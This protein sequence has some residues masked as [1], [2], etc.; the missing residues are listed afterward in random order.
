MVTEPPTN[1]VEPVWHLA[2]TAGF[3]RAIQRLDKPAATR[4]LRY[5]THLTDLADPRLRGKALT[6]HL[7]GMW[8]YRIGDYRVITKINDQQLT[9]IALT[10]GHRSNI[11]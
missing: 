6:G 11:Y 7:T 8:R 10:V 5:L 4:I 2:T 1:P 3:D 9:V